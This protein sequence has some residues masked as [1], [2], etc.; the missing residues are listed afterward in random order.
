[1]RA[2]PASTDSI[3]VS[4]TV[5]DHAPQTLLTIRKLEEQILPL[6][7]IFA[8]EALVAAQAVDLRGRPRL[9]EATGD[10]PAAADPPRGHER[11]VV[12]LTQRRLADPAAVIAGLPPDR[13]PLPS[14]AA[15]DQ[16]LRLPER[17]SPETAVAIQEGTAS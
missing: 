12:S 7:L 10:A 4:E 14:V 17:P 15:Y 16:L 3:P 5:E 8:I 11:R 2:T 1:M 6:R 9:A 13:R